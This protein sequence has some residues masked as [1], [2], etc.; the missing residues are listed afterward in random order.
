MQKALTEN[1]NAEYQRKTAEYQRVL[2]EAD[3]AFKTIVRVLPYSPEAI[4]RYVNLL[5]SIGR[6]EDAR[7]IAV[8]SQKLDPLNANMDNLIQELNRI[9]G[10]RVARRRRRCR[11]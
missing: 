11:P 4:F 6:V 5:V 7:T 8:T 1:N 9:S 10:G 2:R 3:F